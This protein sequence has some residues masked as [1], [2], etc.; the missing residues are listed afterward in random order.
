MSYRIFRFA[1]YALTGVVVAVVVYG[2]EYVTVDLMLEELWELPRWQQEISPGIGLIVAALLL[3]FVGR[4]APPSTSEDYIRAF[5]ERQDRLRIL[6][7]PARLL[8]GIATIGTGGT[9]GLEGPSIYT[10]ATLGSSVQHRLRR[11]F[12][13]KDAKM[14]LVAGAAAGVAAI[15]KAPATGVLFALEAPYKGDVARRALLPALI[16]SAMSYVTF[17]TFTDYSPIFD[18]L[19]SQVLVLEGATLGG[20]AVIGA[21]AGFGAVFFSFVL[22]GAKRIQSDVAPWRRIAGA[23][24][25]L[26]ALVVLSDELFRAPLSLGP[27]AGGELLLWVTE[28]DRSLALIAALFAIR[29]AATA[30]TTAGGGVGGVFIPLA[31]L[32]L[33]LGQFIGGLSLF[34]SAGVRLFPLIGV[35][36]FLGAGYRTPLAA[37]VFIAESTVQTGFVVPALIA[38]A[39]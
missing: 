10:G 37:V 39:V 27:A 23:A 24:I 7:L 8:A 31:V 6:H 9:L 38:V 11:F 33:V 19:R 25:L 14:L 17:T 4:G 30:A 3:R 26:G 28:A 29:I 34:D 5:H 2:F 20:A 16:A 1:A 35:A 32:G 21:L 15:F 22:D 13:E 18:L 36:A 12:T